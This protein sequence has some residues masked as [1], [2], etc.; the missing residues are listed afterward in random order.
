MAIVHFEHRRP[1]KEHNRGFGQSER[2]S[3]QPRAKRE[4]ERPYV[5]RREMWTLARMLLAAAGWMIFQ[6]L[7][8]LATPDSR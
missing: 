8:M 5:L 1:S 4:H 7:P 2:G 3:A 6:F